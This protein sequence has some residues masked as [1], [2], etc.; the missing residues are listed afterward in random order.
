M[1]D[2]PPDP[3]TTELPTQLNFLHPLEKK[4]IAL[5]EIITFFQDNQGFM[6]IGCNKGLIR[7]DG[8]EFKPIEYSIKKGNA[9]SPRVDWQPAKSVTDVFQDHSGIL[10]VSTRTGLFRYDP[11]MESLIPIPNTP[12]TQKISTAHIFDSIELP[13]GELLALSTYGIY[14]I[15]PNTYHYTVILPDHTKQDWL[16]EASAQRALIDKS[17]TLWLGTNAGLEKLDWV[18]KKFTLFKPYPEKP[19]LIEANK[20]NDI[21]E[22]KDGK[23]WLA[24]VDGIVHFNPATNSSTRYAKNENAPYNF[25][26][27]DIQ[28]LLV[29]STGI[30]WAA[31]DGDGLI[32]LEKTKQYPQGRF[33]NHK[34]EP[35]RANSISS[36]QIRTL[37][38]DRGGDIWIGNYP[39]GINYF[40]RSN[41]AI[42]SYARDISN[43]NSLSHSAILAVR[44]DVTGNLW[45]GT[46]GG[47]LNF[48]DR[49]TNAFS[50]YQNEPKNEHSIGGNAVLDVFIDDTGKIWTG[51]WGG[52]ISILD[53]KTNQFTRLP[54]DVLRPKTK[55]ITTSNRLNNATIWSIKEDK[56]KDLWLTTQSGGLSKYDR[57]TN[58]YTHY[59]NIASDPNSISGGAVWMTLEDSKGNF[60]VGTSTGLN[61]MDRAK[62]TFT[63]FKSNPD[64]AHS[65]SNPSATT[66][67]EDSKGR[68]WIGT[69]AGLNLLNPDGKTFTIFNKSD[70]FTDDTI[71][72]IVEDA[73]GELWLATHNGVSVFNPET[74]AVKNYIRDSGNL[75]GGFHTD[76]S[77]FSSRGEVILGGV[78]GL[79]I[80]DYTKLKDNTVIPPVVFTGLKIFA[81]TV[82]VGAPD[83]ILSQS[84]NHTQTIVLDHTQNMFQISFA[85]LN[86]RDSIKN[87]YAYTL[88]G[89][90][91][92]WLN[93]GDQR[94]A[95]YTNLN[96]GTYVFHVKGSNNDDIWNEQ[97]ASITIIQLPPPWK[98]WWAY[99]LY[100]LAFF[101]AIGVFVRS[102]Q[103]KVNYERLIN[104]RMRNLDA[105]KETFLANTSHELRTPLNG[106]IGL[107]DSISTGYAD[108]SPE[109][110]YKAKMI[111]LSG[112]RLANI[113]DDIMEFSQLTNNE[114]TLTICNVQLRPLVENVLAELHDQCSAKYLTTL[115][116]IDENIIIYSNE[117]QLTKIIHHIVDNAIKFTNEGSITLAHSQ[118]EEFDT[119]TVKDTGIGISEE[120]KKK[121]FGAFQQVDTSAKRSAEGT[122]LGLSVIQKLIEL[123]NGK[124]NVES[125]VGKGTSFHIL[126]PRAKPSTIAVIPDEPQKNITPI[127][128]Q[129]NEKIVRLIFSEK[130]SKIETIYYFSHLYAKESSVPTLAP[131]EAQYTILVVDDDAVNRM[132]VK[133]HLHKQGFT[134]LEASD[135]DEAINI[136]TQQNDI[137]LIVL[138]VMMPKMTGYEACV[139]IRKQHN[140]H[141]LPIIFLTAN[142]Q[143][144]EMIKAFCVGG[145][146]FLTKPV[147][148]KKLNEKVNTHLALLKQT[149][150]IDLS[151]NQL[152]SSY[153]LNNTLPTSN[154]PTPLSVDILNQPF[155]PI[156]DAIAYIIEQTYCLIAP[157][158]MIG[159]WIQNSDNFFECI[160]N[161]PSLPAVA[162]HQSIS[163]KELE[164]MIGVVGKEN[165]NTS[166]IKNLIDAAKNGRLGETFLSAWDI[167]CELIFRDNYIIGFIIIGADA[168]D[169]M[170]EEDIAVIT[171]CQAHISAAIT[172]SNKIHALKN[173]LQTD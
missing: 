87:N 18:N 119:I 25:P 159:C 166:L 84:I 128:H 146:D 83:K 144:S 5:G 40:D 16:H 69:D 4:D 68:I 125:T 115:N 77:L 157:A 160:D 82:N 79:R 95:V 56:N 151:F 75:I 80:F 39:A 122:G 23:L 102:Q 136:I 8:Y 38:E 152:T 13:S 7:Y 133:A 132:V 170:M 141:K 54:Y 90:D 130:T 94:T 149:Q 24:T 3:I 47:G 50:N 116:Q 12:N 161:M 120:D 37:F 168:S 113:V 9:Q 121:I 1:V 62:G 33:T 10:W 167:Y 92:D 15:D 86:F 58:T 172:K 123:H 43:P 169:F 88:Q 135:G 28:K 105:I 51:T 93:V 81:N 48:F 21:V 2:T 59:V 91:R 171:Q 44:E 142:H 20:V 103:R 118:D 106:I 52:G 74:K 97:G 73:R 53:P 109:I 139:L 114:L 164:S 65:L 45:L 140:L 163:W 162:S 134:T 96:P 98:T 165:R 150:Q 11:R 155:L 6:W 17:G 70:G 158:E 127:S 61:L 60:W 173:T 156:K 30:L 138:D 111:F 104:Q 153:E 110:K 67:F 99:T 42:T 49:K 85:A 32:T 31:T 78:S 46:D 131:S 112:K 36:N 27:K 22:D 72:T 137:D 101:V 66:L 35:G 124:I 57:K 100:V 154:T 14:V 89:F 145:S 129:D 34:N 55:S 41:T 76:S 143:A 117:Y 71:R 63:H 148:G 126:L 147:S 108:L 26:G 19:E 29:D 107:A 64:N